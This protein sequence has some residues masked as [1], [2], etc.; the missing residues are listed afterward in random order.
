MNTKE[1]V[2]WF[3]RP[4]PPSGIVK[5]EYNDHVLLSQ[6][7]VLCMYNLKQENSGQYLCKIGHTVM[8]PY[9]LE[10]VNNNEP[11]VQAGVY[12]SFYGIYNYCIKEIITEILFVW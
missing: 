9:F 2:T 3:Y 6:D 8:A 5:V 4:I 12:A 10:V 11:T 1:D 7:K